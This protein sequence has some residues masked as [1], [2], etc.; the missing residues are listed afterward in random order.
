MDIYRSIC[1][2][3]FISLSRHARYQ[4]EQVSRRHAWHG[5]CR[6][7]TQQENRVTYMDGHLSIHLS[8]Y[9]VE[10][11][12]LSRRAPYP[13]VQALRR[14]A[15][16]GSCRTPI[17]QE[18]VLKE[19]VVEHI[20]FL[21]INIDLFVGIHSYIYLDTHAAQADWCCNTAL[22]TWFIESLP[23]KRAGS[24]KNEHTHVYLY[25]CVYASFY[26]YVYINL[27]S[28]ADGRCDSPLDARFIETLRSNKAGSSIPI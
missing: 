23:N 15:W 26:L 7:P 12:Y 18:K 27:A 11:L 21:W 25:T 20:N 13:G 24:N 4:D 1:R 28:Q 9:R 14:R 10:L 6:T 22:D 17:R 3:T 2:D 16:H 5:S 8:I 19:R